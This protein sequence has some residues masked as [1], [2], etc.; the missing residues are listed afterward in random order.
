M[1]KRQRLIDELEGIPFSA[2]LTDE[3]IQATLNEANKPPSK[4]K[5]V[6]HTATVAT[7]KKGVA[8]AV[9]ERI[10][11]AQLPVISRSKDEDRQKYGVNIE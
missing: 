6:H 10:K 9:T 3:E 2:T 7:G 11:R 1:E 5:V 8:T 4:N